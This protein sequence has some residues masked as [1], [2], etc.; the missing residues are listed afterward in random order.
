MWFLTHTLQLTRKEKIL[1]IEGGPTFRTGGLGMASSA[2]VQ[3]TA[4]L[5]RKENG[6]ESEIKE[7]SQALEF[8]DL[9]VIA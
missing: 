7:N 6:P 5:V 4:G 3:G 1:G 8:N 9:S 2:T